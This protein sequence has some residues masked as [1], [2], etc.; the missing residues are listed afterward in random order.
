MSVAVS[1]KEAGL[2]NKNITFIYVNLGRQCPNAANKKTVTTE[3]TAE[4]TFHLENGQFTASLM[5]IP[6]PTPDFCPSG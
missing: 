4:A 6:P 1:F 2:R 3:R 5:L